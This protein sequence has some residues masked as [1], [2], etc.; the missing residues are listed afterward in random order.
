MIS[1]F[2]VPDK[3][4]EKALDFEGFSTF[5]HCHRGHPVVGSKATT[6]LRTESRETYES[7]LR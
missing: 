6:H 4:L 2:F 1:A 3:G 5:F 7:D